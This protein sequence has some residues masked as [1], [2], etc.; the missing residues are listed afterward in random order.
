MSFSSS[1]HEKKKPL[2]L[3]TGFFVR[4]E[5]RIAAIDTQAIVRDHRYIKRQE[6]N[7]AL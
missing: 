1:P 7:I 3:I 6:A 5:I 2:W 4:L